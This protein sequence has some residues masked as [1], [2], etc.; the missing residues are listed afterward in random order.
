MMHN[1]TISSV[2]NRC[3]GWVTIPL[4]FIIADQCC[5]LGAGDN[6]SGSESAQEK[7]NH[8]R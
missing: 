7:E 1:W 6:Q 3:V 8:G 4:Y 5:I 2:H